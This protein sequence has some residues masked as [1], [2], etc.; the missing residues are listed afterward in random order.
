MLIGCIVVGNAA[1]FSAFSCYSQS[2]HRLAC[3][4]LR[5]ARWALKS[6][7]IRRSR[8]GWSILPPPSNHPTIHPFVHPS[9]SQSPSSLMPTKPLELLLLSWPQTRKLYHS[10]STPNIHLALED[11][12]EKNPALSACISVFIINIKSPSPHSCHYNAADER[13]SEEKTSR[14]IGNRVQYVHLYVCEL[15]QTLPTCLLRL[16]PQIRR[17]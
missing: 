13:S 4:G 14:W 11:E 6:I 2:A 17:H 10:L 8:C 16:F 12:T 1:I 3:L 5:V 9:P 15:A 7:K